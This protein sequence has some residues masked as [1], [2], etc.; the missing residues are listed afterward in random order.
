MCAQAM[1]NP[2]L[3]FFMLALDHCGI[4]L[5]SQISLLCIAT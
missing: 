5:L 2:H 4:N 3:P 1:H